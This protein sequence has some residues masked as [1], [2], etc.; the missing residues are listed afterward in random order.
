MV[1]FTDQ[2]VESVI[3]DIL[4]CAYDDEMARMFSREGLLRQIKIN[5]SPDHTIIRKD[6]ARN[7]L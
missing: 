6:T 4:R 7:K 3:G 2:K 1:Q 5:T